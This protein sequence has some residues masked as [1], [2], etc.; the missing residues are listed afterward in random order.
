MTRAPTHL[1]TEAK[2]WWRKLVDEFDITDEGGF[3]V[4]QTALEAFDRMRAASVAI[5]TDGLTVVDR[6]G[7]AKPHPL[8]SIER[9]A[10]GQ[11]LAGLKALNLDLEP[12]RPAPG[13][14]PGR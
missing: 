1:S 6:F 7:Q 10:R 11:L 4:L 2:R 9:D 12:L 5:A 3:L 8:L 13:R 14:P